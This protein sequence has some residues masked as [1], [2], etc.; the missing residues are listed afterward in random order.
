MANYVRC[1]HYSNENGANEGVIFTEDMDKLTDEFIPVGCTLSG[2]SVLNIDSL[3]DSF[4]L[5]YHLTRL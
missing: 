5:E 2:E 1:I 3:P 4:P